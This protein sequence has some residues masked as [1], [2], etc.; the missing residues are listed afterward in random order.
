MMMVV[1]VE[2]L[3]AMLLAMVVYLLC[4]LE[5]LQAQFGLMLSGYMS[6][7]RVVAGECSRT[8]WTRHTDTLMSL[9]DVRAQICLV[10]VQSFTEW[11]F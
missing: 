2:L 7:Y 11:T 8:K 1:V 3:V 4:L 5:S 10:P 9:S 6:S